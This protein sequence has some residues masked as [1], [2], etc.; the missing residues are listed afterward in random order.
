M[1]MKNKRRL[2]ECFDIFH[3]EMDSSGLTNLL[4]K[5]R[6]QNPAF[7]LTC[8]IHKLFSV[9]LTLMTNYMFQQAYQRGSNEAIITL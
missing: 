5:V 2:F 7:H 4:A 9:K 3:V 6:N 8:P 1:Q